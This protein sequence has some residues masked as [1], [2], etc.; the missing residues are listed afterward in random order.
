MAE[1]RQKSELRIQVRLLN[2]LVIQQAKLL[3]HATVQADKGDVEPQE[4][5]WDPL[6]ESLEA[7]LC[8]QCQRPTFAFALTRLG[9]L[10]CPD[11]VSSTPVSGKP[12]RR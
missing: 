4:L 6:T 1:L 10:A 7:T 11:C 5:V 8:P 12:P 2:V 9:R 3:I